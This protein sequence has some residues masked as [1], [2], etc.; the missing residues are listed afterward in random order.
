[1]ARSKEFDP[2]AVLDAA[3]DLF[4]ERGYEATSV[5]DLVE[6]LGIARASIYGTYGSKHELYLKAMDRYRDRVTPDNLR[7]LS[8]PG[9]ALPAVRELVERFAAQAV[10]DAERRGCFVV[11][12]AVE[13]G[14]RDQGAARR[15]EASWNS[16]ETG[17]ASALMRAQAQGELSADRNPVAIARFLLVVLQGLQVLGRA[18][19]EPERVRDAVAQALIILD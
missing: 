8:R 2:E 6:H 4:W 18:R 15:V 16:L 10:G 5:A 13:L 3:L 12:T 1:M 11:N 17:L 19:P 14:D 9:A 7:L